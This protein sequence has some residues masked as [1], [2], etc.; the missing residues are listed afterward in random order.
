[1][2]LY[3][4][5]IEKASI[6][7]DK[8]SETYEKSLEQVKSANSIADLVQMN[9]QRLTNLRLKQLM[10]DP[11]TRPICYK[12]LA[13]INQIMDLS[14]LHRAIHVAKTVCR[15]VQG[16][17]DQPTPIGTGFLVG[18]GLIMTNNHVLQ[19]ILSAKNHTAQFDFEYLSNGQFRTSSFFQINPEKFFITDDNLDYSVVALDEFSLN[20]QSKISDYHWNQLSN[21][22]GKFLQGEYVN[23]IQHPNG[24]PKKIAIRENKVIQIN[25]NTIYYTTDTMKGSSGSLVAND[26]WEIVGLHNAGIPDR[27]ENGQWRLLQGGVY[28]YEKDEPCIKW[29][30][31]QGI[32]MDKILE[33]ILNT[34]MERSNQNEL[35]NKL[36]SKFKVT[37]SIRT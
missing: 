15:I 31:N 35:K 8:Q 14:Y 21:T 13:G 33:H 1:M 26:Q 20:G 12:K 16:P 25:E 5:V 24:K 4:S 19:D 23:I 30:T 18:P 37:S 7:F 10:L 17:L 29:K 2:S 27:D 36:L 22:A 28:T 6:E 34:K 32:I 3:F 11:K 9:G